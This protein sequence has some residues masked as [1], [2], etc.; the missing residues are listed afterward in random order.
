M[1]SLDGLPLT[2]STMDIYADQRGRIL[3]SSIAI[4]I[5]TDAFVVLRLVSRKLAQA[6]YWVSGKTA[7]MRKTVC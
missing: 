7:G 6:G 3:G 2:D 1:S 4:F 5:I